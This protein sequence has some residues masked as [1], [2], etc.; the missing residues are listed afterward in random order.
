MQ[1]QVGLLTETSSDPAARGHTEPPC[2]SRRF[3]PNLTLGRSR[4]CSM[5]IRPRLNSDSSMDE[6]PSTFQIKN[7]EFYFGRFRP[8]QARKRSRSEAEESMNQIDPEYE[9]SD[10]C[11]KNRDFYFSGVIDLTEDYQEFNLE[12]REETSLLDQARHIARSKGGEC[13]SIYCEKADTIL[14][15]KCKLYHMFKSSDVLIFGSWCPKCQSILDKAR[16]YAA[17][18]YGRLLSNTVETTILFECSF[19]HQWAADS[20]KFTNQKWCSQCQELAKARRKQ[21]LQQERE[22]EQFEHEKRQR[23]LFD[24]AR[25]KMIQNQNVEQVSLLATEGQI[26]LRARD[27]VQRY[28]N[29]SQYDGGVNFSQAFGV[30]KV[31][32]STLQFLIIRFFPSRLGKE[33][34]TSAFRKLA[35][36]LHP[37]KNRHPSANDAF[38][39]ISQAY[40]QAILQV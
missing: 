2:S 21:E 9:P 14:T 37:D 10:F 13:L 26:D 39:K 38:L 33:A 36:V 27:M 31:L 40:A 23:E 30:Y 5:D 25:R 16:S 22:K 11:L 4:K 32:A 12:Y 15:Y 28:M 17:Q 6:D 1:P 18:N 3:T 24:D 29:S 20:F 8:E 19:G 35:K 34:I 7:Q